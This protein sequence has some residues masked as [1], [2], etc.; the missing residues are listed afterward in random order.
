VKPR[1]PL[2]KPR[3]LRD[4]FRC[5]WRIL[6][7]ARCETCGH[8]CEAHGEHGDAHF[9][10]CTARHCLCKE[11]R[12]RPDPAIIRPLCGNCHGRPARYAGWCLECTNDS[13]TGW[14]IR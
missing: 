13:G 5:A 7:N 3:S 11:W 8:R 10:A 6:V 12:W 9:G 2:D 4:R 1:M 14:D